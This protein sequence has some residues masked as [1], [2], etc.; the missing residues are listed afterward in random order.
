MT[1][2]QRA[3]PVEVGMRLRQARVK[4]RLSQREAAAVAGL[5][6]VTLGSI[7]RADHV[8]GLLTYIQAARALDLPLAELLDGAP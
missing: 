5:S 3:W 2:V 6:S 7:E 4:R 1:E 8:A